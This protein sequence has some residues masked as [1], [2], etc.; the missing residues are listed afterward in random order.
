[1]IISDAILVNTSYR[2]YHFFDNNFFQIDLD[3]PQCN[4][5]TNYSTR[6]IIHIV[7]VFSFRFFAKPLILLR[8]ALR[9]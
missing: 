4:S 8:P 7:T 6:N 5:Y 1:M 2:V 3:I 9:V